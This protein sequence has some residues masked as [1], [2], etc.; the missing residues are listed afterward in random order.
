VLAIPDDEILTI[1][2]TVSSRHNTSI[3]PA[4][5]RQADRTEMVDQYHASY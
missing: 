2:K 3:S 1:L 5:D 4:M